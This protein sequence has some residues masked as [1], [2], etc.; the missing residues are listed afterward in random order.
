MKTISYNLGAQGPIIV[1]SDDSG[2]SKKYEFQEDDFL[3]IVQRASGSKDTTGT[4]IPVDKTV[5]DLMLIL[6][7]KYENWDKDFEKALNEWI[8]AYNPVPKDGPVQNIYALYDD[9]QNVLTIINR[10]TKTE[11][12]LKTDANQN[13]FTDI[14]KFLKE[15]HPNDAGYDQLMKFTQSAKEYVKTMAGLRD[16]GRIL[17]PED[18]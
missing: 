2:A 7:K 11:L 5:E 10:E 13:L 4:D 1:L 14:V 8:M 9:E 16:T 3:D 12:V 15:L 6:A 17:K 18:I